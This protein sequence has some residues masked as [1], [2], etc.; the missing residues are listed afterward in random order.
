MNESAMGYPIPEHG[1]ADRFASPP[2]RQ[3]YDC[4]HELDLNDVMHYRDGLCTFCRRKWA[5]EGDGD[6]EI[7]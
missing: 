2:T 1:E 6:A 4:R 5:D 3:C 7:L